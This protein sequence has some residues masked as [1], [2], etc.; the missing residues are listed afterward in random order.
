MQRDSEELR[1]Q[2]K[3]TWDK[4]SSGWKKWDELTMN[5]LQPIG[6]EIIN[7]L[8]LKETDIVL[9]VATGSGEPGLTIAGIV[10]KGKVIGTDISEGMLSTATANALGREI[11]NYSTQLS[12]ISQLYFENNYFDAISCRMGMMFFPEMLVAIMEMA[13]V[14]KP[15][16]K[17]AVSIWG[18]PEKNFWINAM[19]NAMSKHTDFPSQI[20]GSPGLFRCS[21][22]G[23][24]QDL[25]KQASLKNIIAK[26]VSGKI[27]Y[28]SV[29][30]YWR[31]MTEVAAPIAAAISKLN[32]SQKM[33]VRK[34]VF[35]IIQQ[36]NPEH[37][38]L[39]YNA[40]VISAEK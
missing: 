26:E 32:D 5:F 20:E 21:K 23:F 29:R 17:L 4:F 24:I 13:R 34:E 7:S 27:D 30:H 11:K 10:K 35:A 6:H 2:Q 14:L 31:N 38:L 22:P 33:K 15:G 40:V 37:I 9:D 36:Q 19:M 8:D 25:F 1:E 16:R 39:D 12:D 18:P 28:F 3:Q